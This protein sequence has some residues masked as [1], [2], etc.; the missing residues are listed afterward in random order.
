M[1]PTTSC[2]CFL[3]KTNFVDSHY[4]LI[5]FILIFL[6]TSLKKK[7]EKKSV[8]RKDGLQKLVVFECFFNT[9]NIP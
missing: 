6:I 7:K 3:L 8:G 1:V 4:S 9:N 2:F 5:Y